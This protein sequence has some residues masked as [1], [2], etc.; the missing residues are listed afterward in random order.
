MKNLSYNLILILTLYICVN[1]T[2]VNAQFT[3]INITDTATG[4]RPM[5][6]ISHT[7]QNNAVI[8]YAGAIT[9]YSFT[10]DGGIS[11]SMPLN[12]DTLGFNS[13]ICA[14]NVGN[15]Y[16]VSVIDSSRLA[17]YK[18]INGGV[19]FQRKSIVTGAYSHSG[20]YPV[21]VYDLT[22]TSPYANR[23]YVGWTDITN[24]ALHLISKSS[25]GGLTWSTPVIMSQYGYGPSISISPNGQINEIFWGS[26]LP[27]ALDVYH[28]NKST[29]GGVTFSSGQIIDSGY[30]ISAYFTLFFPSISCDISGGSRNGNI[31]FVFSGGS[32]S[33]TGI[34]CFLARSTDNGNTWTTHIRITTDPVNN[35]FHHKPWIAVNNSGNIAINYYDFRNSPP[36][37]PAPNANSMCEAWLSRSTDGGVTFTNDKLSSAMSPRSGADHGNIGIDYWGNRIIPAWTDERDSVHFKIYTAITGTLTVTGQ[38]TYKDN[39]QP[40]TNGFVK[41]L[42]YDNPT[43]SIVTVDS[44]IIQSNGQYTLS[45]VPPQDSVDIMFYQND[46]NLDFVPTYYISTTDW[47]QATKIYASQNLTNINGQVYRITNITNPYN[48]GGQTFQNTSQGQVPIKDAIIYAQIGNVYK[49]YGISLGDGT[50]NSDKLPPGNYTLTACR[51]GFNPVM[52]NVTITTGN[53]SNINFNFNFPIGIQPISAKIPSSFKLYQNYPNPFNPSTN[54][55]FDLPKDQRVKII[56]YDILGREIAMPVDEELKGGSYNIS[57]NA[58]SFAS[59]V[60]FYRIETESFIATKKL[61]LVK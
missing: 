39:N 7:N 40:V 11:W 49:N 26:G 50:Y 13:Q 47:R 36:S 55:K 17:V 14:D 35:T 61:L 5:V 16:V 34:D 52:Q 56:I 4:T 12:L 42:F 9:E 33:S 20:R 28:Y 25:D 19:S 27:G 37:P 51:M 6:A 43:R 18:S 54:I 59:G 44:T 8:I 41:A 45:H 15:F 53:L 1:I 57:W 32:F 23:I 58:S 46:D 38:V 60:Y 30:T 2:H 31:Y 22:A 3:N 29:D 48:I 24:G 21:I 10:T